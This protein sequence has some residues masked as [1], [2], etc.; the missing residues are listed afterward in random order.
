MFFYVFNGRWNMETRSLVM[1]VRFESAEY[2]FRISFAVTFVDL[3][4]II[5]KKSVSK[6][7]NLLLTYGLDFS[8]LHQQIATSLNALVHSA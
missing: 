6:I 2:R 5:T 1:K 7:M 4:F 8:S 3:I